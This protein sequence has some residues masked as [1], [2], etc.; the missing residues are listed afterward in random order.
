MPEGVSDAVRGLAEFHYVD[1]PCFDGVLASGG[2]AVSRL[3]RASANRPYRSDHEARA[4]LRGGAAALPKGRR[5]ARRG[6]LHQEPRRHRPSPLRSRGRARALRGGA[7]ALPKGRRRA[8]RGQL[9]QEPRR[10]RAFAAPITRARASVTRRR[11]RSTKRSAPCSARPIASRGLG[12]IDEAKGAIAAALRALA[13]GVGALRQYSRTLFDRRRA[14]S[15]R[16]PRRDAE[17]P[18]ASRGREGVGVDRAAG[19]DRK[20]SRQ[21]RLR[22]LFQRRD[23][24]AP[25]PRRFG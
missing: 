1:R 2:K 4:A 7:A 10:N 17:E 23:L 22:P 20:A 14:Q 9:H 3:H 11:C 19:P 8:R 15:P 25:H 13:R 24:H 5:R 18:P 12:D 21:E 16:P 6:Q